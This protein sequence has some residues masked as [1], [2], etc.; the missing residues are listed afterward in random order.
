MHTRRTDFIGFIGKHWESNKT[1]TEKAIEFIVENQ[2]FSQ[3]FKFFKILMNNI[4]CGA[5]SSNIQIHSTN[6][7]FGITITELHHSSTWLSQPSQQTWTI[8]WLM[9]YNTVCYC[10]IYLKK[11][12]KYMIISGIRRWL[13]DLM[14]DCCWILVIVKINIKLFGEKIRLLFNR[15]N[16]NWT[17][18][19][20]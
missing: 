8:L 19:Y 1:Y 14:P 7:L 16:Q 13:T 12:R 20:F 9:N 5:F 17:K 15:G 3:I 18:I 2:K 4:W 10:Y 11:N 6:F